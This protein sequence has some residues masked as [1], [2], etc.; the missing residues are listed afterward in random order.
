MAIDIDSTRAFVRGNLI[1]RAAGKV[2]IDLVEFPGEPGETDV[3]RG[4]RFLLSHLGM[5]FSSACLLPVPRADA[6][7]IAA[8][9]LS[10]NP[11]RG[12]TTP[13]AE[14]RVRAVCREFDEDVRV[15][16]GC[17]HQ[18][19]KNQIV[20]SRGRCPYLLGM[21]LDLGLIALDSRRVGILWI[22]DED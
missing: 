15:L 18:I 1:H 12:R 2:L 20:S 9:I 13:D 22:G 8:T 6:A 10:P 3:R 16:S 19:A 5:H 7:F 17:E 14:A 21:T 11:W 4:S